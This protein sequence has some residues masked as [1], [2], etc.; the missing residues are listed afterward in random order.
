MAAL[1]Y[2][3]RKIAL[4]KTFCIQ[5]SADNKPRLAELV[6]TSFRLGTLISAGRLEYDDAVSLI[7]WRLE[8]RFDYDSNVTP[9]WMDS[10]ERGQDSG[11]TADSLANENIKPKRF[12][13]EPLPVIDPRDWQDRPIPH[14]EWF[15]EGL[16]PRRTVTNLSG[17]G[18]SGKT[19]IILQMVAA[20]ALQTIWFGKVVAVGPCLYYGAEDE[21]DEL[22]RRLAT[23][24]ERA[25]KQLSDLD[26]VRLIPMAGLD[27]V[28]AEPDRSGKISETD[29]FPKLKAEADAFSHDALNRCKS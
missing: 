15:V 16:I 14:R 10:L 5:L 7:E 18:G 21:A 29:L 1:R 20:S 25:G 12:D 22:H 6:D 4:S 11:Q 13:D 8:T 3:R 26:G 19:E 9:L 23:I 24:V 2:L 27:A 28:L 17:A